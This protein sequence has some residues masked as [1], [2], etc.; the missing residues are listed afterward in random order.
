MLRQ[1]NLSGDDEMMT[2]RATIKSVERM[3][4]E[5]RRLILANE[6][7]IENWK[8][9]RGCTVLRSEAK[10]KVSD[11]RIMENALKAYCRDVSIVARPTGKRVK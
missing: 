11:A 10:R 3:L 4:D 8:G 5:I 9:R 7:A 1:L 2:A 6:S